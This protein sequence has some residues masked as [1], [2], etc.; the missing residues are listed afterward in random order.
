MS[1]LKAGEYTIVPTETYRITRNCS[2]CGGKS[3]YR[4][5][6]KFRVNGNG[7]L[8]DVWLIYQCSQCKHTY[9]LTIYSRV[10]KDTLNKTEYGAFLKDDPQLTFRYG[11]DRNLF[12]KNG[13]Q[14]QEGPPYSLVLMDGEGKENTIY[15][16]NPFRL[17]IREDKLAA[18]VLG[19]SRSEVKRMLDTKMILLRKQAQDVLVSWT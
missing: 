8:L 4:S 6:N 3:V 11:L 12:Q 5:T 18:E 7:K 9:N 13:A 19:V 17:R 15:V 14:I 1:Y 2:G 16:H 10:N